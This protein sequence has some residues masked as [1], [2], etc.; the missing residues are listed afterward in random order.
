MKKYLEKQIENFI[1]KYESKSQTKWGKPLV[2]FADAD[3]TSLKSV[4]SPAHATGQ[5]VIERPTVILAYFVPFLKDMA[6]TN[7]EAGTASPQW[8]LG[9]EETNAMFGELNQHIINLLK[10]EGYRAAVSP[11]AGAFDRELLISNWSQRHIAYAAGLGTFGLNNMLITKRGC[12]GRIS[13]VVTDLPVTPDSPMKEEL[14]IYKRSGKCGLCADRCPSGALTRNGY[15]REKCFQVC[16]ENAA[17]YNSFGNSY[18]S[19]PGQ[20]AEDTGSEV[21][22]KC[23]AGMPCAF[24]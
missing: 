13:T 22:G 5:D 18:A 11:E 23:V 17:I 1:R 20:P 8:A 16:R 3:L 24:L 4:I 10:G 14:C 9:Y 6:Q 19:E 7:I 15:D 2:G 12:C 21:C